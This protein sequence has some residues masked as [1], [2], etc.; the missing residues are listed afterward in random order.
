MACM[1]LVP[2]DKF[3][4]HRHSL[5]CNRVTIDDGQSATCKNA[6][7]QRWPFD[8]LPHNRR[9]KAPIAFLTPN[10]ER[11]RCSH[12]HADQE[13]NLK[14]AC[15]EKISKHLAV[16]A[17]G[18]GSRLRMCVP[19]TE[20]VHDSASLVIDV[21]HELLSVATMSFEPEASC[22]ISTRGLHRVRDDPNVVLSQKSSQYTSG[23]KSES[24][25]NV[26]TQESDSG[27]W[28]F[29]GA[30]RLKANPHPRISRVS[31]WLQLS[32]RQRSICSSW[33][34]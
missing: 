23:L 13:M 24:Q 16:L 8:R 5:S 34:G 26:A 15:P 33:G 2:S 25:L 12:D 11:S 31:H 19:F 7:Q 28:Q 20:V 10:T 9:G 22:A 1:W 6:R 30:G 17:R 18:R 32:A 4:T 3:H 21:V 27:L 14:P 29:D